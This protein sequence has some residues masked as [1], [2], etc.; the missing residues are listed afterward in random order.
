MTPVS[1][2]SPPVIQKDVMKENKCTLSVM[3]R[4]HIPLAKGKKKGIECG[5][6]PGNFA[7]GFY[8]CIWRRKAPINNQ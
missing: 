3:N 8:I 7:A 4:R 1:S 2:Q 6:V 5:V